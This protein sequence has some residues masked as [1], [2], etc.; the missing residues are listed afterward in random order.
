MVN[1][2][3]VRRSSRREKRVEV[4]PHVHL[5]WQEKHACD[6]WGS[7]VLVR[8]NRGGK[9]C[10]NSAGGLVLGGSRW[11]SIVHRSQPVIS[12]VSD[13]KPDPCSALLHGASSVGSSKR[14]RGQVE[15]VKT[16]ERDIYRLWCGMSGI[17]IKES[18][19]LL[20]I[21]KKLPTGQGLEALRE[22]KGQIL[23][24]AS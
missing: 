13:S 12:V 7:T 24:E 2:P 4:L 5:R 10:S 17:R 15:T 16:Q 18:K 3:F 21:I 1:G 11:I 22:W 19:D 6:V 23:Y 8:A 14:G 20:L 9:P